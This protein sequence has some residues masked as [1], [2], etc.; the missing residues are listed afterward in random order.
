MQEV[1]R[2][3]VNDWI[4]TSRTFDEVI[5]FDAMVRD[6]TAPWRIYPAWAA[7]A[8]NGNAYHPNAMGHTV[9][10]QEIALGVFRDLWGADS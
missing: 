2:Q 7:P 3:A 8:F 10:G 5:D 4:R 6:P 1:S 9:M